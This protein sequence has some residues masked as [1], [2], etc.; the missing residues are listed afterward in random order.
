MAS[1]EFSMKR[2]ILLLAMTSS[3]SM[4]Y[5]PPLVNI[6]T[7]LPLAVDPEALTPSTILANGVEAIGGRRNLEAIQSFQLHGLMHL[8]NNR[9]V[10][11]IE[12]ATSQGGSVLGVMSFVSLGQTRF[13]SDG[14]TAWEQS[15]EPD[16]SAKYTIIDQAT[17][18]Q[19]VQQINWLEWF[20]TLPI[21]L[22]NMKYDG[23]TEFDGESCLQ[24]KIQTSALSTEVAYF[25]KKTHRP[26]GRRTVESTPN[27][28]AIVDVYFRDWRLVD[29]LLL[30]HTVVF[31]RDG[32]QVTMKFDLIDI[33][34]VDEL[35]FAL[36]EQV[37]EL[38]DQS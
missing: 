18:S 15:F 31:N 35:L 26:K 19:K 28:D 7:S 4:A 34:N 13:G 5:S 10:V 2:A 27:G 1:M 32:K 14:V 12:L 38:R 20:T 30:F 29:E 33:D 37:K 6:F 24:L 17:L 9:P 8:P 21:H 16:Q 22:K 36:P 25:S 11:E 23:V 3:A